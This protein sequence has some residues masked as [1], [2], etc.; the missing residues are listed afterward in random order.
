MYLKLER[1]KVF[2]KDINKLKFSN[3]HYSKFIIYIGKLLEKTILP[4]EAKDHLLKGNWQG[5]REFHI[6]G[7]LLVI[8]KIE[9]NILYLVRIGSHSQLFN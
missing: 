6:S 8:Y 3:D 1:T 7:D 9:N 4:K 5:Y 2:I